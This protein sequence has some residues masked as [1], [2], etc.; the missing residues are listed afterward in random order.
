MQKVNLYYTLDEENLKPRFLGTFAND[1]VASDVGKRTGREL[2]VSFNAEI[3]C[4]SDWF[5]VAVKW[6]GYK[7]VWSDHK[8]N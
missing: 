2:Y 1:S 6:D 4:A 7:K 5:P 3:L 8:E